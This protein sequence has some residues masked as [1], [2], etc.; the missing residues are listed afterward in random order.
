MNRQPT[1]LLVDLQL[2]E[3]DQ[4]EQTRAAYRPVLSAVG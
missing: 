2:A 4:P 1:E 3:S